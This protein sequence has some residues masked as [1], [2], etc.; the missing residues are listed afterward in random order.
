MSSVQNIL[1]SIVIP[2]SKGDAN[3]W[4]YFLYFLQ[5]Q[6]YTYLHSLGTGIFSQIND[7]LHWKIRLKLGS[8]SSCYTL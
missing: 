5:R 8:A 6:S 4:K 3:V 2:I 7:L 1:V